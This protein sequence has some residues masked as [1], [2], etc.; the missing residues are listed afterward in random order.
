MS[1]SSLSDSSSNS[2]LEKTRANLLQEQAQLKKEI[3][4][5]KA[6]AQRFQNDLQMAQD[7]YN[8]G[9][10]AF[11][12]RTKKIADLF[13]G[14]LKSDE[15]LILKVQELMREA[16]ENEQKANDLRAELEEHQF[17]KTQNETMIEDVQNELQKQQE[18]LEKKKGELQKAEALYE[19]ATNELNKAKQKK[20]EL[21]SSLSPIAAAL[22]VNEINEE[23]FRVLKQRMEQINPVYEKPLRDLAW[24]SGLELRSLAGNDV[25]AFLNGVVKVANTLKAQTNEQKRLE[26]EVLAKLEGLKRKTSEKEKEVAILEETAKKL[27]DEIDQRKRIK[28]EE[29]KKEQEDIKKRVNEVRMKEFNNI[30]KVLERMGV[31]KL[32]TPDTTIDEAVDIQCSTIMKLARKSVEYKQLYES[33]DYESRKRLQKDIGVIGDVADCII[34][35]NRVLLRRLK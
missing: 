27:A 28:A 29:V 11:L 3:R 19:T 24:T 10:M 14:Q 6:K 8:I 13:G 12:K 16:E 32:L 30:K 5:A 26:S 34:S 18:S 7:A 23:F 31:S 2:E 22:N 20:N 9:E 35:S 15:D 17:A 25:V 21:L 1:S 4:T 33:R